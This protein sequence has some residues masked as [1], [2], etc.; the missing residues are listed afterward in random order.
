LQALVLLNDPVYL[1][2][3]RVLAERM[4][5]SGADEKA[6]LAA[7]FRLCTSRRAGEREVS[8]LGGL[9]ERQVARFRA[10]PGEAEKLILVGEAARDEKIPAWELAAW[11][12]VASTLLNLDETISN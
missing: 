7:G 2:A 10:A 8:A 6:R 12:V 9:L 4:I 11:T 5:K 1:E 3:A